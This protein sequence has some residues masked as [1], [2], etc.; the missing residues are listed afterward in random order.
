MP[1]KKIIGKSHPLRK[2]FRNSLEY[3][4]THSRKKLMAVGYVE[5]QILCGF[6]KAENFYRVRDE[7]GRPLN[8][9]AD[10]LPEGDILLNASSFDREFEVHK[11]IGDF[12]LFMLGMF[13]DA[14]AGKRGK[15]FLLGT[16]IVPG[17]KLSEL[18]MLQGRQS[19]KI[20]SEFGKEEKEIFAELAKNFNLYMNVLEL[21]RIYLKSSGQF[22][23][24]KLLLGGEN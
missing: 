10:M 19:Y 5:E 3:G 23:K 6:I 18:Y 8:D 2:L 21:A 12:A 1:E 22:P 16:I 11:H 9:I 4:L 15:E 14:L 17:G 13:P 24:G 20:A 7:N